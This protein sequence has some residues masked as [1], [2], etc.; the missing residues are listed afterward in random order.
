ML[1]ST[2]KTMIA[3]AGKSGAGISRELHIT[4]AAFTQFL[5]SDF[6]QVKR[7]I[8]IASLCDFEIVL[9]NKNGLEIKLSPDQASETENK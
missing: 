7:F 2:I 8:K 3:A 6:L 9:R 4:R 5:N 1:K